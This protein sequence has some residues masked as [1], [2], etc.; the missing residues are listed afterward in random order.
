MTNKFTEKE[1]IN[2]SRELSN[3]PEVI[4][5]RGSQT[6][7]GIVASMVEFVYR[8]LNSDV[9]SVY[10]LIKLY[11]AEQI[12]TCSEAVSKLTELYELAPL[13]TRDPESLNERS[14]LRIQQA[15]EA[16]V[17][18]KGALKT[19]SIN[20]LSALIEN[21]VSQGS[22]GKSP[23]YAQE[24]C[25]RLLIESVGLVELIQQ[26]GS[27]F[28]ELV[29][30]Y[31]R[32]DF[33]AVSLQN[34]L[35]RSNAAIS[36]LGNNL[37][38]PNEAKLTLSIVHG[39]LNQNASPKKDITKPKYTGPVTPL[40]G[41][42][43]EMIGATTPFIVHEYDVR[44]IDDTDPNAEI[45]YTD[46]QGED[47]VLIA[48]PLS[49]VPSLRHN[50][51]DS[52][53]RRTESGI[54]RQAQSGTLVGGPRY[55]SSHDREIGPVLLSSLL[56][57]SNIEYDSV[58]K[59]YS[60][61]NSAA[62]VP[63]LK[64]YVHPNSV[65]I[66][67]RVGNVDSD[68][69]EDQHG[70]TTLPIEDFYT[71]EEV[72]VTDDGT[73]SLID[74]TGAVVG[75][76]SYSKGEVYLESTT[77]ID[78][79]SAVTITY[80]YLPL[81]EGRSYIATS[82]SPTSDGYF[83]TWDNFSLWLGNS[84]ETSQITYIEDASVP[85]NHIETLD[86]L[87]TAFRSVARTERSLNT[88]TFSEDYGGSSSRIAFPYRDLI[89]Q[90]AQPFAPV[91]NTTP[92]DYN[93]ALG[94]SLQSRRSSYGR[95]TLA[96]QV[97]VSSDSVLTGVS[98]TPVLPETT[99]SYTGGGVLLTDAALDAV[100]V[101]DDVHVTSPVDC[102]VKVLTISDGG[103]TVRPEV[104]MPITES[105][106]DTL[107]TSSA[108][109]ATVT[110]DRLTVTALSSG[111]EVEMSVS[112]EG[113]GLSGTVT[114]F[115]SRLA[116]GQDATISEAITD[117]G[118]NIK[119]GDMVVERNGDVARPIGAVKSISGNEVVLSLTSAGYAYPFKD[120]D[121]YSL[122]WSRYKACAAPIRSL[123]DKLYNQLY[124]DEVLVKGA[125]YLNSGSGQNAFYQAVLTLRDN[126]AELRNQYLN[127]DAH[128][129]NTADGLLNYFRQDKIGALTELLEQ[130]RFSEIAGLTPATLSARSSVEQLM[131]EASNL[132]GGDM[133][134]WRQGG[135]L[136]LSNDFAAQSDHPTGIR[137]LGNFEDVEEP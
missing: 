100:E 94:L 40:P 103:I 44:M 107:D 86:E 119:A 2:K 97:S 25:L 77:D 55:L 14:L 136:D 104:P 46:S 36:L 114:A 82:G 90:N 115:T 4:D 132:M 37:R 128:V 12:A 32:S 85:S 89:Q 24:R 6:A 59:V 58:A 16:A 131:S 137:L 26:S 39:L 112:E 122:G 63:F 29:E 20:R 101:G 15:A 65:T 123:S 67:F 11:T 118:Y 129:V 126:I 3:S 96:S 7:E 106:P 111:P 110:R 105:V 57:E 13:V 38:D 127:Y 47:D 79:T 1:V 109:L 45:K 54:L 8:S 68:A 84:L 93:Q 98:R 116:L 33:E 41:N 130:C 95:D 87:V 62:F 117:F 133:T 48:A 64:T 51:P 72:V 17:F 18:D 28:S 52:A 31:R 80:D 75:D 56:H 70:A 92:T 22:G 34:N 102:H 35:S 27:R 66:R 5:R 120:L 76:I 71:T 81:Y 99:F 10:S 135:G 125:S 113:L 42:P 23:Q 73:G 50:V 69:Y 49:D 134:Y 61:V 108:I 21:F 30:D 91:W 19:E 9:D 60:H 83:E 43:A 74:S 78:P 88:F 53:V 124:S 121:I